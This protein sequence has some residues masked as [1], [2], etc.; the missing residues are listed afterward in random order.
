LRLQCTNLFNKF[1]V[2]YFVAFHYLCAIHHSGVS[3]E[4]LKMMHVVKRYCR[5][6]SNIQP[7]QQANDGL[8][9]Y[10]KIGNIP[11]RNDCL[12]SWSSSSHCRNPAQRS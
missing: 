4:M 1:R 11:P 3:M 5:C 12:T 2:K 8:V 7:F 6:F 9:A 10:C